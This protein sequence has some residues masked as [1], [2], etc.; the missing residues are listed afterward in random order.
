[1]IKYQ[2][3][4]YGIFLCIFLFVTQLFTLYSAYY[5][6]DNNTIPFPI[7]FII[8]ILL[9]IA[10]I[11][12]YK[13][14]ITIDNEKIEAKYGIGLLKKSILLNDIN[15]DSIENPKIP[16]YYGIG[17]RLTPKGWLWNIKFGH[18]IYIQNKNKTKTFLVGTDDY[19]TIKNILKNKEQ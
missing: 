16:W 8:F 13:L 12:F 18:A 2:K 1:M 11:L 19:Q 9:L 5:Q 17:I 10:I 4:Q 14:N 6:T 7:S 3:T 15:I